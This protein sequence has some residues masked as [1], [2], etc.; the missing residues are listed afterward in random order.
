MENA[1]AKAE[2]ASAKANDALTCGSL[3]IRITHSLAEAIYALAIASPFS[4][5]DVNLLLWCLNVPFE[6]GYLR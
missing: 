1:I 4:F 5:S 6:F 2:I 3:C